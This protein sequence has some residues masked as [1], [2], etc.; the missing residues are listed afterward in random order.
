MS[1][2]SYTVSGM[3]CANCVRHVTEA[4]QSIPGVTS[5]EVVLDSG[6]L[7]V[8]ADALD[9]AAVA[10]AVDEAGYAIAR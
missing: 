3:S 9:D 1:T 8:T 4:V 5:V 2:R 10:D 7:T 6:L